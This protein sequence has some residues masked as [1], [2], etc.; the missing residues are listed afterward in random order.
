MEQHHTVATW[1]TSRSQEAGD[2]RTILMIYVPRGSES[3]EREI[4]GILHGG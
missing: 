1:I 3:T 2:G 4:C